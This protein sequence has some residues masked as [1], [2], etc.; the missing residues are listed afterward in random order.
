MHILIAD[1]DEMVLKALQL[2]LEDKGYII[3]TA[4]NGQDLI[5]KLNN[6]Q[7]DLV[8][9]DNDMPLMTGLQVLQEMRLVERFK[10]IPVIVLSAGNAKKPV[11]QLGGYYFN[12]ISTLHE[13]L[14]AKIQ[15]ISMQTW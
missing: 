15:E 8:I 6:D 10:N 12:K 4:Q 7:Y 1:D 11:E 13:K 9:T 5:A 3:A 2:N 14:Y